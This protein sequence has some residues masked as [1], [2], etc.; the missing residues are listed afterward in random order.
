MGHIDDVGSGGESA[1]GGREGETDRGMAGAEGGRG[2][3][4]R[5]ERRRGTVAEGGG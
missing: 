3:I 2:R 5:R 1:R 4:V